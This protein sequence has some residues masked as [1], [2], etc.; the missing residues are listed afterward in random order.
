MRASS[1]GLWAAVPMI[2][3]QIRLG[4][5][6]P[7]KRF[8]VS[9]F[10]KI[11]VIYT[12]FMHFEPKVCRFRTYLLQFLQ[13]ECLGLLLNSLKF[14][15]YFASHRPVVAQLLK[16]GGCGPYS[17]PK[18]ESLGKTFLLSPSLISCISTIFKG[19][20]QCL[21]ELL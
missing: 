9:H 13:L 10:L 21:Y 16:D 15:I 8:W 12:I 11:M 1:F 18:I 2:L 17:P 5:I 7:F 19:F 14:S 3:K 6:T 20:T 4:H